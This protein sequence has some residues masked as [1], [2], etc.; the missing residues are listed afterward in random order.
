MLKIEMIETEDF[1]ARVPE[2]LDAVLECPAAANRRYTEGGK[3]PMLSLIFLRNCQQ[4]R[5]V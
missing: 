4:R 2:V 5:A 3:A 1:K